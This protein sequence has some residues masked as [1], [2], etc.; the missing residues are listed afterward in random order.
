MNKTR[1]RKIIAVVLVVALI[2][3]MQVHTL[4]DRPKVYNVRPRV[5][6]GLMFFIISGNDVQLNGR[7]PG[8]TSASITI[9][10]TIT[11]DGQVYNVVT[12]DNAAFAHIGISVLDLS[13]ATNLT[14]IGHAAFVGNNITNLDLS[15]LT[16]LATIGEGA[17]AANNITT[18]NLSGLTNLNYIGMSAFKFNEITTIDLSGLS[19][20]TTIGSWAF[21]V[22]NITTVDLSRLTSLTH[23]GDRAFDESVIITGA[24]PGLNINVNP[25]TG[26]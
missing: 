3:G 16:N 14:T 21:S 1:L 15:G 2:L 5:Y 11:V 26:R 25:P 23:I 10:G 17:F 7:A 20:L 12:V 13:S 9:P 19:E 24:P 22:N 6:D 18:L 4:A 8:N